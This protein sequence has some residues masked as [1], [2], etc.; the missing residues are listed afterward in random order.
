MPRVDRLRRYLGVLL[1][2][3]AGIAQAQLSPPDPDWREAEATPPPLRMERLIPL[4]M[5]QSTLRFGVDPASVSLGTDGVVRYVVV[6]RS[7]TGT[8]NAFFEGIRCST[9]EFRV[10]A[11][12]TP[13]S[14]WVP[15]KDVL[16]RPLHDNS[17]S[18]HS[19]LIART[20][21]CVG[22]GANRSADQVVRDLSSS[23]DRRF[24]N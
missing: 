3:A 1:A 12:H 5:P 19:L 18:R 17:V 24:V 23:V 8:V 9:A 6:A 22:S 2:L 13:D 4:E 10:Y 15:V 20:G 16:W 14:G 7:N 11:R 21:A